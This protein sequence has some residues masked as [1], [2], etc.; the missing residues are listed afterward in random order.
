LKP[1]C[2]VETNYLVG[3]VTGRLVSEDY[4]DQLVRHVFSDIHV[5]LPEVCLMEALKWFESERKARDR[6]HA[7]LRKQTHEAKR[8]RVSEL[9]PDLASHLELSLVRSDEYLGYMELRLYET[10]DSFARDGE[11]IHLTY[12]ILD[13][14]MDI[15]YIDDPSDNL[16]LHCVAH[17]ARKHPQEKKAFVS[18]NTKDFK[19]PG[20]E[21]F[22]RKIGVKYFARAEAALGWLRATA[23]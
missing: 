13:D 19:D 11:L 6:F 21:A 14:F 7:D 12:D 8:D 3:V 2:Y 22:L 17:H 23:P 4:A 15:N 5:V 10:I 18:D 20:V 1:I 9:A 16:I